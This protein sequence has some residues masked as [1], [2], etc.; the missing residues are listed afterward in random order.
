FERDIIRFAG[1]QLGCG[2][3]GPLGRGRQ[4]QIR[5]HKPAISMLGAQEPHAM[6]QTTL[7]LRELQTPIKARYQAQPEAARITLRVKSAGSDLAD[8]LHCAVAP[9]AVTDVTW[10]SGAHPGVGGVGDVPCSGDL[11]L[12]ALAACQ[13]ITLRM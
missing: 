10:L 9:D 8:P 4:R 12:G 7:N 13:E 1:D 11:L 5:S 6:A 2:E 3:R